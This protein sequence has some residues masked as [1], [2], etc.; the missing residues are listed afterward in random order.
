MQQQLQSAGEM[1]QQLQE[2][3]ELLQ[4]RRSSM[5]RAATMS[6]RRS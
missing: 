3:K 5:S 6:R 2:A 4:Q 1:K